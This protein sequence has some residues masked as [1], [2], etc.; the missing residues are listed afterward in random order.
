[1]NG[2]HHKS[3]PTASRAEQKSSLSPKQLLE[4]DDG[5][6]FSANGVQLWNGIHAWLRGHSPLFPFPCNHR[7]FPNPLSRPPGPRRKQ[8]SYRVCVCVSVCARACASVPALGTS[9][10]RRAWAFWGWQCGKPPAWQA[11]AGSLYLLVWRSGCGDDRVQSGSLR[12]ITAPH[13]FRSLLIPF[14]Q[15]HPSLL[16]PSSVPHLWIKAPARPLCVSPLMLASTLWLFPPNS[17]RPSGEVLFGKE[18]GR[19][20]A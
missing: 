10:C 5:S 18:G 16:P 8:T 2:P 13:S 4:T 14:S 15:A 1:M 11:E 9:A 7:P 6:R 19:E 12:G 17:F 3:L 20:G